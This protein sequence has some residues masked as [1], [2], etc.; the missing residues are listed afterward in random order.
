MDKTALAASEPLFGLLDFNL[1][2]L[3]YACFLFKEVIIPFPIG[4]L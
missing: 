2:H 4:L 3:S 1:P